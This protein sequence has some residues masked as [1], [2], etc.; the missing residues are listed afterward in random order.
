M[1]I[2]L[3]I[4]EVIKDYSSS[5]LSLE[6]PED[7][8]IAVLVVAN[9]HSQ[10]KYLAYRDD[11]CYEDDLTQIPKMSCKLKEKNVNLPKGVI[12]DAHREE[13]DKYWE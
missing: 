3:V 7:Y 13:Y 11:D 10:A 1:N 6:P 4:S 9:S 5:Y 12:K 8:Q 2:Y